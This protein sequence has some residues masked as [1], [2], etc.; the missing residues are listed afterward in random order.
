MDSGFLAVNLDNLMLEARHCAIA[1]SAMNNQ[2]LT[3]TPEFQK[4]GAEVSAEIG[5]RCLI[6]YAISPN[7]LSALQR[8]RDEQRHLYLTTTALPPGPV[9]ALILC[10]P[11]PQDL[12]RH[13]FVFDPAHLDVIFFGPRRVRLGYGLEYLIVPNNDLNTLVTSEVPFTLTEGL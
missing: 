4:T 9:M 7:I 10:L 6:Y 1:P 11:R 2:E 8:M 3:H 12:R 5:N 13:A